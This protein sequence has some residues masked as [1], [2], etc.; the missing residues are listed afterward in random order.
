MRSRVLDNPAAAAAARRVFAGAES[1]LFQARRG[2]HLV[3]AA[4]AMAPARL[5]LSASLPRQKRSRHKSSGGQSACGGRR[6]AAHRKRRPLHG[7]GF[8]AP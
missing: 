3:A 5:R 1:P 4:E 7:L 2:G 8:G 6:R